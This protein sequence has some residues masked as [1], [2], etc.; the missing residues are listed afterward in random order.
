MLRGMA[1][2]QLWNLGVGYPQLLQMRWTPGGPLRIPA[3]AFEMLGIPRDIL[4]GFERRGQ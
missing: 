4:I 3:E 1:P 2:E